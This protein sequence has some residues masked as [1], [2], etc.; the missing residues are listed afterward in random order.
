[1]DAGTTFE[2]HLPAVLPTEAQP[3]AAEPVAAPAPQAGRVVVVDD[4]VSVGNYI[5]EVLRDGGF[6]VV[7]F[8]ESP[9]ALRYLESNPADVAALLTDQIMPVLSGAEL[10]ERVRQ[11]RPEL[12]IALITGYSR[13]S[14]FD[15]IQALGIDQVLRKP[16]RIDELL[17][18]VRAMLDLAPA[19]PRRATADVVTGDAE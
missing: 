16:F 14:D 17:D 8:N 7:V 9:A 13:E 6:D 3:T 12:P 19:S 5:G 15:K 2:V 18:S 1:V 10:T 4:E 11:L